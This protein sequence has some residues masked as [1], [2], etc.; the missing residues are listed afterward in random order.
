MLKSLFVLYVVSQMAQAKELSNSDQRKVMAAI[1]ENNLSSLKELLKDRPSWPEFGDFKRGGGQYILWLA[2]NPTPWHTG[3]SQNQ[4]PNY[5]EYRICRPEIAK[6]LLGEG[7]KPTEQFFGGETTKNG[8]LRGAIIS[9]CGSVVELLVPKM[10]KEDVMSATFDY[11]IHEFQDLVNDPEKTPGIVKSAQVLAT[12]NKNNCDDSDK[13]GAFCE[14]EKHVKNQIMTFMTAE[15]SRMRAES[16]EGKTRA[17]VREICYE[18]EEIDR[19]TMEI[20]E[21]KE[22]GK[23]SGLVDLIKLKNWGDELYDRRKKQDAL[24]KAHQELTKKKF[25][26]NSCAE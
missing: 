25:D 10:A 2:T 1:Q 12:F 18:Q 8:H 4:A 19:V 24:K 26:M 17:A 13:G 22:K 23:V 5:R 21:E 20:R 14:A 16:P 15:E 9:G 6:Y 11:K 3:R 7:V